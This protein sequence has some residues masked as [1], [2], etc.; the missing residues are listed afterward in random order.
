M[1]KSYLLALPILSLCLA[2]CYEI[3]DLEQ[4]Y[5][6][7][8]KPAEFT[9]FEYG[10][11]YSDQTTFMRLRFILSRYKNEGKL[12]LHYTD[13][14]GAD[15]FLQGESI[16]ITSFFNDHPE[17]GTAYAIYY[18]LQNLMP[19]TNYWAGLSYSDPGCEPLHTKVV[20]FTTSAIERRC[21]C[22]DYSSDYMVVRS[23]FRYVPSGSTYGCLIGTD[24]NL[25]LEHC[26]ESRKVGSH[27]IEGNEEDFR[28]RFEGLQ[29]E[30]TYYYRA[31]VTYRGRTY[32]SRVYEKYSW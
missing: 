8:Y 4:S 9:E 1:K 15:P 11:N 26:L 21:D 23:L 6:D 19:E 13:V 7:Q 5:K 28:E 2:S 17:S 10:T 20:N 29:P 16:D 32:Y 18:D 30:A 24:T 12:M 3:E 27:A 31:Y 14:E 25:T 22:Y